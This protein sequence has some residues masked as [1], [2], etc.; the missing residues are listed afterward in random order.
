MRHLKLFEN[1]NSEPWWKEYKKYDLHTYPV[2]IPKEDVHVDLSGDIDTHP[3]LTWHSPKTGKKVYAY[4][5]ARMA[6]QSDKKYARIGKL[7][8]RKVGSIKTRCHW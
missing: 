6:A 5:K 2:N 4:T 3:V 1:F 8:S 7:S